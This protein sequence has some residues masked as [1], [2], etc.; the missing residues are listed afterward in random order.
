MWDA[1]SATRSPFFSKG[2]IRYADRY[3]GH[4]VHT[5]YVKSKEGGRTVKTPVIVVYAV[6]P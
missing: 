1:Y 4:V 6:R 2:I 5:E 3:N